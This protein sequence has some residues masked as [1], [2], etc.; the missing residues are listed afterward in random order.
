MIITD[1][2]VGR[3]VRMRNGKTTIIRSVDRSSSP[4][5]LNVHTT[6]GDVYTNDGTK[7]YGLV[8]DYDLVEFVGGHSTVEL[9]EA[10]SITAEDADFEDNGQFIQKVP[11][12]ESNAKRFLKMLEA[13]GIYELVV[14]TDMGEVR[15]KLN[16]ENK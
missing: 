5:H 6:S 13:Q 11:S 2:D 16:T 14:V 10:P 1:K 8:S 12:A 9:S 3:L 4:R 7:Y 15:C